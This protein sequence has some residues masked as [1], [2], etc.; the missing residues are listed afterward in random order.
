MK[1]LKRVLSLA[2]A[3]V[4]LLGMMVVGANAAFADQSSIKYTTAV[5]TLVGLGVING[6]EG[7]TFQPNGTLTRAQAAKIVA[8]VKAGSNETTI[9]YYEGNTKFTDVGANHKWAEGAINYCVSLNIISGMTD[10]TYAPDAQ[11]T[12]AQLAKMMLVALGIA[13]ES[14]ESTLSLTGANWQLNAI[15]MATENHLFDGM[16]NSFVATRPVTRQE[17]CQI[18]FN[19]LME[20][21]YKYTPTLTGTVVDHTTTDTLLVECYG[22]TENPN[23]VDAYGHPATEYTFT[24]GRQAIQVSH[25]PILTYTKGVTA[26]QLQKDILNAGY[27]LDTTAALA[28]SRNGGTGS[29]S[30]AELSSAIS[31]KTMLG[32]N[33]VKLEVFANATTK[34]VNKLVITVTYLSQVTGYTK[35]DATTTNVDERTL[36]IA[37]VTTGSTMTINP[38]DFS[39]FNAIYTAYTGNL[40]SGAPTYVTVVPQYDNSSTAAALDA[41]LATPV[42]AA[43][44][45]YN[46]SSNTLTVGGTTY[47]Y[48][49]TAAA[50]TNPLKTTTTDTVASTSLGKSVN[51]YTDSYGYVLGVSPVADTTPTNYALVM[52]YDSYMMAGQQVKLLKTDGT[53]TIVNAKVGTPAVNTALGATTA[54]AASGSPATTAVTK[55]STLVSYREIDGVYYLTI[56]SAATSSAFGTQSVTGVTKATPSVG[57]GI[58]ADA[59]TVFVVLNAQGVA[60]VYTGIA[61]VPTISSGTYQSI[62]KGNMVSYVFVTDG[63][64]QG[65]AAAELIYVF[66]TTYTVGGTDA[67]PTYTY[68]VLKDGELKTVTFGADVHTII[69]GKGIY[70]ITAY[71]NDGNA[72]AVRDA[73]APNNTPLTGSGDTVTYFAN[74]TLVAGSTSVGVNA[75]TKYISVNALNAMSVA[76]AGD[77][78]L[79]TSK[80]IVVP[81]VVNGAATSTAAIV[82]I[83]G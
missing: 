83:V 16:D 37:A 30:A 46:S 10:K 78:V 49:G 62:G 80:V 44:N 57:T 18:M 67:K 11:I 40:N 6:M 48:A 23:A 75:N 59:K 24:D 52:D 29:Y 9:G 19:T 41:A 27:R 56:Q 5:D 43:L 68:N 7:N 50:T 2:L 63:T 61:N 3:T 73:A 26:D 12:G 66:D 20:K 69:D 58:Y 77:I 45:S 4:M 76:S 1:N 71:G 36:T 25:A 72:S 53:Y 14:K 64:P 74:D 8:Y 54:P 22:A 60:T 38:K 35:D 28:Y 51:V 13:P 82:F 81:T 65:D 42:V 79:N 55:G 17:A 33:G 47:N 31:G 70:E 21:V 39:G 34:T 15:R 32:G